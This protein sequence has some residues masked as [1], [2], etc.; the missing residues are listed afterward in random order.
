[1][2]SIKVNNVLIICRTNFL[3]LVY[4]SEFPY[5]SKAHTYLLSSAYNEA[6]SQRDE[7]TV[8]LK[9][10]RGRDLHLQQTGKQKFDCV[11]STS[12]LR[13]ESRRQQETHEN[14][15]KNLKMDVSARSL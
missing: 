10:V 11:K 4:Y 1:M 9:G 8:I 5:K 2:L 15:S 6:T 13:D 7:I 14:A 12:H 3:L